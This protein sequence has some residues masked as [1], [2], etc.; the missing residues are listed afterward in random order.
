MEKENGY[1]VAAIFLVVV[2]FFLNYQYQKQKQVL[3]DY[4]SALDDANSNIDDANSEI[5]DAQGNA[6]SDYD[7]MG[8]ALDNLTTIDSVPNPD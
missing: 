6:W 7:S 3:Q 8:S 2:L 5:E 1:K 4:K